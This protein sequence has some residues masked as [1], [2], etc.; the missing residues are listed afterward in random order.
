[1]EPIKKE[2]SAKFECVIEAVP[3]ATVTW[4]I[5]GKELTTKDGVQIEK[6]VANNK[7]SLI[8]PKAN[9]A[10]HGGVITVKAT[11]PIGTAQHDVNL[12]ILDAPKFLSKLE[13]VVVN[14]TGTAEFVCKFMAN[15]AP[16]SIKWFKNETEEVD[17]SEFVEIVSTHESSIM[18]LLNCKPSDSGATYQVKIVNDLG[19]ASSN[20]ASLNV[21][22]A[23]VFEAEFP[24][25]NVLRDKEAKFE[26]V[27]K[28]NPK[29]NVIWLLN[30]K[31]LTSRDGVRVEKD[32]AK[33]KY[34][35][36]IPKVVA[37]GSI[38]VRATNE[39]G[40]V[41][42]TCQLDV[43]DVPRALNKLE[44]ATV[45]EGE[46][47]KFTVKFSGKPRP[48]V[49]WFRDEEEIVQSESFEIVES[50][51]DEITLT[52]VSAKSAEHT[53]NYYAKISNEFGEA[54]SNKAALTINS[55]LF[56]IPL[57]LFE[58]PI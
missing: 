58:D 39:F 30:G 8:I 44:N 9:P 48:Q 50:S 47:A 32:V 29:P 20:K 51:E 2:E 19:E 49:K 56:V 45:K 3:K 7:Y 14:E 34:S 41:E 38:T 42:K 17:I 1:M 28:G 5:N 33:D 54:V 25:Q 26:V 37:A 13:N 27:I 12:N 55:N 31:E 22:S 10:V 21:S 4:S 23:P 6:D 40:T 35:L 16:S 46:S 15:P 52:I 57:F 53:G 43:L 11:N 24:D 36:V 18:R